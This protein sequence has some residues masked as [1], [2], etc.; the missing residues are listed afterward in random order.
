MDRPEIVRVLE[1]TGWKIKGAGNA[2][3]RLGLKPSTLRYRMKKL[4]IT[5]PAR[6]AR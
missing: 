3:E 4:G 1:R 2:A 6:D 5:R